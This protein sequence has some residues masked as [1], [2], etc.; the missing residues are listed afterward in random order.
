MKKRDEFGNEVFNDCQL[1]GEFM[2]TIVAAEQDLYPDCKKYTQLNFTMK[3]LYIKILNNHI[4]KSFD[5]MLKLFI[6]AMAK[7]SKIPSSYYESKK[8]L[9]ELRLGYENIH[10]C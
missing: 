6:D 2:Y 3:L 4:N 9:I 1:D 10:A 8:L 5:M 7:G